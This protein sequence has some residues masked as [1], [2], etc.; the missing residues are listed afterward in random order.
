MYIDYVHVYIHMYIY[1]IYPFI[2]TLYMYLLKLIVLTPTM[3]YT[4]T[5]HVLV[6]TMYMYNA[7]LEYNVHCTLAS[8][9]YV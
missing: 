5:C 1:I 3:V 7:V 4:N 8:C 2:I 6:Y 9:T